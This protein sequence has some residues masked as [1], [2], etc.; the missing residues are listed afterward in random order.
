MGYQSSD[1]HAMTPFMDSMANQGIKLTNYYSMYLCSPARA[2]LLTGRYVFRYGMQYNVVQPTAP[3]GLP[4]GEKLMPEYFK[5]AGYA[6]HMVG[7]WHLGMYLED[8]LPHRR[9]FDTFL[10]YLNDEEDYWTHQVK[11]WR[12]LSFQHHGASYSVLDRGKKFY[13]F[14]Y[15][16]KDGYINETTHIPR[17]GPDYIG[18][19]STTVFTDRAIKIVEKHAEE[20]DTQPLFLYFA[21]QALHTPINPPDLSVFN[22]EQ[23]K[24]IDDITTDRLIRKEFARVRRGTWRGVLLYLDMSVERLVKSLEATGLMDNA[25]IIVTSDNG[26]CRMYGGSNFPLRGIKHTYWEGGNKVPG[27]VYSPALLPR[28]VWGTAYDRLMHV[29]DWLPTLSSLAGYYV[30]KSYVDGK[31]HW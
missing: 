15:G 22:E 14:G 20:N 6:T 25:I 8:Y 2:S 18:K 12:H 5:D 21:S 1:L 31:D 3:W 11:K 24:A 17:H 29:T 19:Y 10:G 30:D 9:G 26:G 27:F 4:L 13:D 23:L 28:H 7:K 16:D